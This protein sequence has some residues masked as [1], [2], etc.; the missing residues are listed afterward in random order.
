[1]EAMC[2]RGRT[3]APTEGENKNASSWRAMA[4]RRFYFVVLIVNVPLGC[5]RL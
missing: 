5:A 1:M 3:A 4:L 2:G